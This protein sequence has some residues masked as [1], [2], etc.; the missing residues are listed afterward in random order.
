[1]G[2]D[3]S[4][5]NSP[6]NVSSI[7][8][9]SYNVEWGFIT[10][11]NDI[12]YDACGHKLPHTKIAQDTHLKLIAKDIGIVFPDICFLQEIGS[13][14]AIQLIANNIKNMFNITYKYYYSNNSETGYQGVGLLIKDTI[15]EICNVKSIPNFYLNRALCVSFEYNN[16]IY[17]IVGVHLKSLCDGKTEKDTQEQLGQLAAIYK[18]CRETENVI[19]TGDFNNV[20]TSQPIQKMNDYKY[21]NLYD[22]NFYIPNIVGN[23]NT[24]FSAHNN[25]TEKGS[26]IDYMFYRNIKPVSFHIINYQRETIVDNQQYR[27]ETSDHLP[28]LGIFNLLN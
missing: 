2:N 18:F 28:I 4:L 14:D 1:M 23:D 20:E 6:F 24:E 22:T 3:I 25:S 17:N 8:V 16:N 13:I 15:S 9:M 5:K 10:L 26:K 27:S 12:K 21:S 7:R 11:P 19:I